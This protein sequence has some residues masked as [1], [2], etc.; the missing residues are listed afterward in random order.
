LKYSP[1]NLQH[2]NIQQLS[3][4]IDGDSTKY[5]FLSFNAD[6]NFVLEGFNTLC[7]AVP[8]GE[9]HGI[10]RD[11]YLKCNFM[12]VLGIS[13]NNTGGRFQAQKLGNVMVNLTFRKPLDKNVHCVVLGQFQQVLSIDK[14]QNV[15]IDS[16]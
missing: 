13:P 1:F 2:F 9:D 4:Y 16:I 14:H 7:L 11:E 15:S 3:C 8:E 5:S 12:V 10:S 6:D